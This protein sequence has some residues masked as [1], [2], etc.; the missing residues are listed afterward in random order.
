MFSWSP[1]PATATPTSPLLADSVAQALFR[2]ASS[3]VKVVK[4]V[5]EVNCRRALC[6]WTDS[7]SSSCAKSG[8]MRR[9]STLTCVWGDL[10]RTEPPCP[11]LQFICNVKVDPGGRVTGVLHDPIVTRVPTIVPGRCF[12]DMKEPSRVPLRLLYITTSSTL[13]DP[14]GVR[15]Y[16]MPWPR[17]EARCVK[18][19]GWN[20]YT[21]TGL[22]MVH[23]NQETNPHIEE[24]VLDEIILL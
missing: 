21:W 12:K 19:E 2:E 17:A 10:H 24:E 4:T 14:R 23:I 18:R 13:T 7:H 15:V 16:P 5:S 11:R 9:C 8:I 20:L 6:A 1:P 22:N 3:E